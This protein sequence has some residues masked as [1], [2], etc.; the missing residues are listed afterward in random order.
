MAATAPHWSMPS[1]SG[2][3]RFVPSEHLKA[4]SSVVWAIAATNGD[5]HYK[6]ASTQL[7]SHA[8]MV[9]VGHH[10]TT[11]SESGKSAD[12]RPFFQ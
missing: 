11:I 10:A 9:V 6:Q 5:E 1:A 3:S 4:Q 2:G 12:V 8:N 7:D